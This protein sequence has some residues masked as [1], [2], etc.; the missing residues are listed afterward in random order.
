MQLSVVFLAA[1]ASLALATPAVEKSH[2]V[3]RQKGPV[4]PS[5]P[6]CCSHLPG[7]CQPS[8]AKQFDKVEA[9]DYF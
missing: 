3:A 7:V 9:F 4:T 5:R 6:S 2:L 8:C 1:F